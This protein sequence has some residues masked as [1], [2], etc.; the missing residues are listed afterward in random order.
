MYSFSSLTPHARKVL[1]KAAAAT[2]RTPYAPRIPVT[3]QARTPRTP[4]NR[5]VPGTPLHKL[6]RL[7]AAAEPPKPQP[8]AG[9]AEHVLED[10]ADMAFGPSWREDAVEE[11]RARA[12]LAEHIRALNVATCSRRTR[13]QRI[14]A[15]AAASQ[16][17]STT[18][19]RPSA[20]RKSAAVQACQ[21]R[22]RPRVER[23]GVCP[24]VRLRFKQPVLSEAEKASLGAEGRTLFRALLRQLEA[25]NRHPAVS[26]ARKRFLPP[27]EAASGLGEAA[28]VFDG[29]RTAPSTP[30]RLASSTSSSS[31]R[32]LRARHAVDAPSTSRAAHAVSV[33]LG[34]GLRP[35]SATP[36]SKP[37]EGAAAAAA[38]AA[39]LAASMQPAS[40]PPLSNMAAQTPAVVVLDSDDDRQ[41]AEN[42]EI[43]PLDEGDLECLGEEA[44]TLV[45]TLTRNLRRQQRL[46]AAVG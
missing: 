44:S 12:A 2:P 46:A 27:P 45:R 14:I 5:A 19:G 31:S 20:L 32:P 28:A 34:A 4:L 10:M 29:T 21:V 24:G 35:A 26:T 8:R 36:A 43:Y 33:P 16:K 41:A 6:P 38:A 9:A 37:P 15:T 13:S 7:K 3:P 23:S 1:G 25:K 18:H 30:A 17:Q 42:L 39:S 40:C 11:A 22:A